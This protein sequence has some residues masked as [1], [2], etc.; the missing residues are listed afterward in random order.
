MKIDAKEICRVFG[1]EIKALDDTGRVGGHGVLFSSE[2]DPDLLREFFTKSTDFF[3]EGEQ[4]DIPLVLYHHGQDGKLKARKLANKAT[5][6][7]DEVGVWVEAQLNIRDKY[8]KAVLKMVKAGK[9]GW[10]TGSAPHLVE[11][12]EVKADVYCI[13]SWPIVEVSLTPCPVEPRTLA[14]SIDQTKGLGIDFKGYYSDECE[15]DTEDD[16]QCEDGKLAKGI[17][18]G[19]IGRKALHEGLCQ[20]I[21]DL[22]EDGRDRGLLLKSVAREGLCEVTAV[23]DF[24]SG[25]ADPTNPQ[26]KAFAR[27]LG[28]EYQVLKDMQGPPKD[29]SIK[30]LFEDQLSSEE[31]KTWELW[32][33]FCKV[34]SR[35][36][37]ATV[38]AALA[39]T[40][41]DYKAKVKEAVT[42]YSTRLAG[43]VTGQLED[44][45]EGGHDYTFYLRA[46]AD[47][48]SEDFVSAKNIAAEDHCSLAVSAL[49]S[50]HA[51]M[52]GNGEPRIKAGRPISE[53]RM[54][55]FKQHVAKMKELL[56]EQ[57]DYL[58]SLEPRASEAE[59]RA[60]QSEDLRAQF[61]ANQIRAE[62]IEKL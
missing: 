4:F 25:K 20:F 24:L 42:E 49:K 46:L 44:Y 51:R 59:V 19:N 62:V 16:C 48:T 32:N 37:T 5:A 10:S 6:K 30:G 45:F 60:V 18:V 3:N 28:V 7:V 29:N 11:K 1:S 15:C 14:M 2:K 36:A 56:K 57:E 22:V 17:N 12:E 53:K 8:E 13:K 27:V 31:W 26:L 23:E 35:I 47:P 9:L 41:F 50:V 40:S 61:R 58:A 33:A 34:V 54:G 55:I 43:V 39:G 52:L 38:G 21:D